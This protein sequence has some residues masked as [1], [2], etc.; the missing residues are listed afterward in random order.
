MVD[1]AR[2]WDWGYLST[3]LPREILHKVAIAKPP[4]ILLGKDMPGWRW[5]H[6]HRFSS[7]SVYNI[8]NNGFIRIQI[9]LWLAAH[10]RLLTN[11]ERKRRHLVVLDVCELCSGGPETVSPVLRE[12][13]MAQSIWE[14]VIQQSMVT[15]F[16]SMP[17]NEWLETNLKDIDGFNCEPN[18]WKEFFGGDNLDVVEEQ[19]LPPYGCKLCVPRRFSIMLLENCGRVCGCFLQ[20]FYGYGGGTETFR[21]DFE[22]FS[23]KVPKPCPKVSIP[24]M[25]ILILPE[26]F[27]CVQLVELEVLVWAENLHASMK[28]D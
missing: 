12:C 17:L 20:A 2:E 21:E 13:T 9:F 4:N 11:V 5:E 26:R 16:Y 23:M 6:D 10:D 3:I 1:N 19:M 27:G 14:V 18:S 7:K 24:L 28:H 25:K 15:A 8:L 22:T